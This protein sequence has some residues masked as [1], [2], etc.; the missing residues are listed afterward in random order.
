MS[1]RE[2][3]TISITPDLRQRVK[4]QAEKEGRN[5]SNMVAELLKRGMQKGSQAA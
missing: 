1:K 3:M 4:K 5:V 2:V